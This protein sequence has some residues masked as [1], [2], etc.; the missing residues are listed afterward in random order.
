M[1]RAIILREARATNIGSLPK[2]S[3]AV[4]DLMTVNDDL[5]GYRLTH[6]GQPQSGVHHRPS[7]AKSISAKAAPLQCSD[8]IVAYGMR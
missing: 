8:G 7:S 6:E 4:F 2:R 5:A 3:P 1:R